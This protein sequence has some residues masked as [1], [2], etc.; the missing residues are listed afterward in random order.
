[1]TQMDVM[2]VTSATFFSLRQSHRPHSSSGREIASIEGTVAMFWK[3]T[4][5]QK[6]YYCHFR[7][8]P[9]ASKEINEIIY[10]KKVNVQHISILCLK[11]NLHFSSTF[12][13]NTALTWDIFMVFKDT[14]DWM[15]NLVS[16]CVCKNFYMGRTHHILKISLTRNKYN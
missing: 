11:Q 14:L 16:V 5:D 7:K 9:S 4:W 15:H 6:K 3:G 13:Q 2:D 12:M 10:I 8:I 1:M